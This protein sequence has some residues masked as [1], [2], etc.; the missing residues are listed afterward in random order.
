MCEMWRIVYF[1]GNSQRHCSYCNDFLQF[2]CRQKK[3]CADTKHFMDYWMEGC[4]WGCPPAGQRVHGTIKKPSHVSLTS[5]NSQHNLNNLTFLFR[6]ETPWPSK[7][8]GVQ[9]RAEGETWVYDSFLKW[10]FYCDTICILDLTSSTIAF[11]TPSCSLS[12]F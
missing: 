4:P 5:F 7:L 12:F 1:C 2:K 8:G 10:V 9:L 3:L 11:L 6:H